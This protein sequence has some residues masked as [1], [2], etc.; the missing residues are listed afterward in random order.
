M[1]PFE[2]YNP[3]PT[4]SHPP[5]GSKDGWLMLIQSEDDWAAWMEQEDRR[6]KFL[7]PPSEN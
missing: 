7:Y 2:P 3:N 5:A 6:E 1:R 4:D